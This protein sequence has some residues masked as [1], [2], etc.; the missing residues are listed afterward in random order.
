MKTTTEIPT[1]NQVRKMNR[2]NFAKFIFS[3]NE[4]IKQYN[5]DL[6][7]D[8]A[9]IIKY[10]YNSDNYRNENQEIIT[11]KEV[12]KEYIFY[13]REQ[14]THLVDAS[15]SKTITHLDLVF[16]Y[17]E[18]FKIVIVANCDYLHNI[19]FAEVTNLN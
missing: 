18:K 8:I 12:V 13:V 5:F 7:H 14:G 10:A 11:N 4:T 19:E 6:F 9:K 16:N 15:D 1:A 3:K 17:V 2:D